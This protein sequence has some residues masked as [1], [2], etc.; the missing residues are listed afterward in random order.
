MTGPPEEGATKTA[1]RDWARR[2]RRD[3]DWEDVSGRV[4]QGLQAWPPLTGARTV[5]VF[6]PPPDEVTRL[7]M[8]LEGPETNSQSVNL[9]EHA[10]GRDGA[11]WTT[12]TVPLAEFNE[13]DLSQVAILGLWNPSDQ[14]GA[15]LSCEVIVDDI[16][17]E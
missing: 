14:R 12:F 17:F 2:A 5:L 8:K 10:A 1:L 3:V 11:G 6:L 4:V 9:I 13:I 15:F 16:R 7:E